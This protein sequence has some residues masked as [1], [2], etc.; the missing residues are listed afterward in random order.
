M[1]KIIS[2]SLVM[3]MILVTLAGCGGQKAGDS[4][5]KVIDIQLTQ[6]EYAFGVDKNQPEL[7]DEV[8]VHC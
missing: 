2:L 4:Q 8:N 7:L 3:V 6:E 5:V 1:K